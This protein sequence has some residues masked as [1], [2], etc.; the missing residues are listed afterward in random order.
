MNNFI[1]RS[2]GVQM[3]SLAGDQRRL[4]SKMLG[5][6]CALVAELQHA[7]PCTPQGRELEQICIEIM[8]GSPCG[9]IAERLV[10]FGDTALAPEA[11]PNLHQMHSSSNVLDRNATA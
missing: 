1:I 11:P 4:E 7:N 3:V 9:H 5:L 8:S 6:K 10:R 2:I